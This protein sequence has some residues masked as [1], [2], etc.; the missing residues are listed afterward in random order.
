MVKN[1]FGNAVSNSFS[2]LFNF[3]VRLKVFSNFPCFSRIQNYNL[4]PERD[5]HVNT[6][7]WS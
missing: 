7:Q 4:L 1:A 2:L 5:V 6:A 3:T